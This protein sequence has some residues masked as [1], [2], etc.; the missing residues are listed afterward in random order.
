MYIY[1]TP[2]TWDRILECVHDHYQDSSA[3]VFF[4]YK[5]EDQTINGHYLD[6]ITESHHGNTSGS[7]NEE[8]INDP[9]FSCIHDS[10]ADNVPPFIGQDYDTNSAEG[11]MSH[12]LIHSETVRNEGLPVL[13]VSSTTHP[14]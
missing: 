5:L 14:L 12:L 6:R 8:T 4:L 13:A 9:Q 10:S 2:H 11:F 7:I 1:H 3:N